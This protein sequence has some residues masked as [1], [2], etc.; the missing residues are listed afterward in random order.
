MNIFKPIKM[1]TIQNL[2]ITKMDFPHFQN[3]WLKQ[4]SGIKIIKMCFKRKMLY[5]CFESFSSVG[6]LSLGTSKYF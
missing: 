5:K 1:Q 4:S 2:A 6:L 3:K